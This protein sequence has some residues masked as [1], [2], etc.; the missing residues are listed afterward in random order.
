VKTSSAGNATKETK[1]TATHLNKAKDNA[2]ANVTS[3]AHKKDLDGN[4]LKAVKDSQDNKT[5]IIV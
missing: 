4:I 1:K 2:T 3:V 5:L